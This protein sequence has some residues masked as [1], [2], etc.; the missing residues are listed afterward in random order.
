DLLGRAEVSVPVAV[1]PTEAQVKGYL[2]SLSNWGRWGGEDELG[3]VNLI[4]PA[5]RVAA[6][7]LVTDGVSV[8]CARP[9]A[10]DIAADTTVQPM[11][12]MVDSGE[13]R[14][15]DSPERLL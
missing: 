10:T 2:R 4:T 5:K 6:A 3:T 15:T 13:G 7:Q 9:I 14:D 8:S 11:R 1:V 12:F